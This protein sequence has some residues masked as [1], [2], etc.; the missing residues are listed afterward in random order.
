MICTLFDVWI[1]CSCFLNL[2]VNNIIIVIM[3][4][5]IKAEQQ[6]VIAAASPVLNDL[7]PK[8]RYKQHNIVYS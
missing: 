5:T 2:N 8:C 7:I 3:I 1:A 4:P 6:S